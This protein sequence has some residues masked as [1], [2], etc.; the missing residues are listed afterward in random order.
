MGLSISDLL[1]FFFFR[2]VHSICASLATETLDALSLFLRDSSDTCISG[3]QKLLRPAV[4]LQHILR[5]VDL[6]A[7][8]DKIVVKQHLSS[9]SNIF[10]SSFS[11]A[12]KAL[13]YVHFS[14]PKA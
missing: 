10:S 4:S 3:V 12:E 8:F 6:G 13:W 14:S 11:E 7:T 5:I 2:P 1:V 9:S